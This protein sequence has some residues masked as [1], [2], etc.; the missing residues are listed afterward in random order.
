MCLEKPYG[1]TVPQN[2]LMCV[3]AMLNNILSFCCHALV[4]VWFNSPNF[5]HMLSDLSTMEDKACHDLVVLDLS[6]GAV[7]AHTVGNTKEATLKLAICTSEGWSTFWPACPTRPRWP[8]LYNKGT[9]GDITEAGSRTSSLGWG[10]K[11]DW[12]DP[13]N[14]TGSNVEAHILI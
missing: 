8:C 2:I 12:V 5:W 4:K 14:V 11:W 13:M 6:A 3:G 9:A 10:G 7:E 1:T